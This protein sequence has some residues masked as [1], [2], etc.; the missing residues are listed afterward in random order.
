MK[1]ILSTLL[2]VAILVVGVAGSLSSCSMGG[3]GGGVAS[4]FVMPEGGFDTETPITITFYHSMGAG[5]RDILDDAIED[6]RKLYPNITID[7]Q[8]FGD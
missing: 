8:S 2:L 6:F 3:G 5:L 7:H 1:R 4:D